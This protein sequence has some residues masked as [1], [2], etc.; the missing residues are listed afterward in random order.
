MFALLNGHA[1]PPRSAP[2]EGTDP[3]IPGFSWQATPCFPLA[4]AHCHGLRVAQHV[5]G[6]VTCTWRGGSRA[7]TWGRVSRS[8]SGVQAVLPSFLPSPTSQPQVSCRGQTVR[9]GISQIQG[10]TIDVKVTPLRSC[11]RNNKMIDIEAPKSHST[12]NCLQRATLLASLW[13]GNSLDEP[14]PRACLP[15]AQFSCLGPHQGRG[16]KFYVP[17]GW[18]L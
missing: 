13:Q 3:G 5:S 1:S 4:I 18:E 2:Q 7:G 9:A 8:P 6:S 16:Y 15:F 10:G 17:T 12:P 11:T 14:L